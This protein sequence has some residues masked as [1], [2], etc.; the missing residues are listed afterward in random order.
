M[1]HNTVFFCGYAHHCFSKFFCK[2]RPYKVRLFPE[3]HNWLAEEQGRL[4]MKCKRCK[5]WNV[6]C[7]TQVIR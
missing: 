1:K 5:K 7:H 6:A 3:K 4:P 2:V